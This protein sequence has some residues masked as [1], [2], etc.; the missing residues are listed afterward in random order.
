[1][2]YELRSIKDRLGV[3]Q[4]DSEMEIDE[5][6]RGPGSMPMVYEGATRIVEGRTCLCGFNDS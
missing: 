3:M 6:G 4:L 5:T 1:M 2:V